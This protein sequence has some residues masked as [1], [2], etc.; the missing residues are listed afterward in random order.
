MGTFFAK[1]EELTRKWYLINAEG[2]PLGRLAVEAAKILRGKNKPIFTP[3]VDTGDHVIIVNADKCVLT[4]A[5]KPGELIYRHSGYPG[6][7]KSVSRAEMMEKT[8]VKAV[9][10]AVKGM[11]PHN[12][13]GDATLKKLRVYAGPDHDHEAQM[14]EEIK[15][16]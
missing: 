16:S 10:R 2:M 3:H 5:N 4:G 9:M 1:R 14:P 13:L 6:G 7:L 15:F 11:L 12:K 8:P